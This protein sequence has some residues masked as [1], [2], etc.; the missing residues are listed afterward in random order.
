M[1]RTGAIVRIRIIGIQNSIQHAIQIV[2]TC[3]D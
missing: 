1:K 3:L 2:F